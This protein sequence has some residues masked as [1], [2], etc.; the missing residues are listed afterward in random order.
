MIIPFVKTFDADLFGTR[1]RGF[2]LRGNG[3]TPPYMQAVWYGSS[4]GDGNGHGDGEDDSRAEDYR[5][6]LIEGRFAPG[7]W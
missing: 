1:P 5:W 7:Y 4:N 3:W 2:A 6:P